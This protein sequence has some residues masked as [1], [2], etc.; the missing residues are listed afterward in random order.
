MKSFFKKIGK[1]LK[2]LG[3][4]IMKVMNSK[5]G[6]VIG[7]VSLAFGIGSIFKA[8]FEGVGKVATQTLV[9]EGSKEAI[10]VAGETAAEGASKIAV[11]NAVNINKDLAAKAAEKTGAALKQ[12]AGKL[13]AGLADVVTQTSGLLEKAAASG[14]ELNAASITET[15]TRTLNA[16]KNV[17]PPVLQEVTNTTASVLQNAPQ[18]VA[19]EI[20]TLGSYDPTTG[21]F[22]YGNQTLEATASIDSPLSSQA[23][24]TDPR[25]TTTEVEL[26]KLQSMKP[27]EVRDF[28]KNPENRAM[29]EDLSTIP[30]A[31]LTE[32]GQLRGVQ[33]FSSFGEAWKGGDSL[34]NKTGNVFERAM[35]YDV[36]E[37]TKGSLKGYAG[38]LP[39]LATA[40][41]TA[42][43]L[44]G[45]PEV[46]TPTMPNR[47]AP[48]IVA[49]LQNQ[50]ATT[51]YT[52]P[53]PTYD[54]TRQISTGANPFQ[55]MSSIRQNA[56]FSNIYGSLNSLAGV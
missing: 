41:K 27:S 47:Y 37:L 13:D 8:M 14:A 7:M 17:V 48:S 23:S 30:G 28:L 25:M 38:N 22:G 3:K 53:S 29:Y 31:K 1:G 20:T 9:Q 43:L 21:G 5:I 16:T 51:M 39:V 56:G 24:M 12:S 45:P 32:A 26:N 49:D 54:F 35:S 52:A 11:E 19:S 18:N 42:S 55:A 36:G 44:A 4:G 46:V 2:K 34:L 15:A 10:N 33:E 40:Q 50:A 6:R